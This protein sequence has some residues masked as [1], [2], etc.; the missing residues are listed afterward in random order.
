MTSVKLDGRRYQAPI[1]TELSSLVSLSTRFI[2]PRVKAGQAFMSG[3]K[4]LRKCTVVLQSNR[5][6]WSA[7]WPQPC[8]V[9]HAFVCIRPRTQKL[10]KN[11]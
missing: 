9:T 2:I 10:T 11:I 5:A 1:Q 4:C 3:V 6:R 8:H 7:Q